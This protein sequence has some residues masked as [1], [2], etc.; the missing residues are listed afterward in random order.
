M[1]EISDP[2][3][4]QQYGQHSL[5]NLAGI[6]RNHQSCVLSALL[7]AMLRLGQSFCFF[8]YLAKAQKLKTFEVCMTQICV[9]AKHPIKNNN[10]VGLY[11]MLK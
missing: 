1:D 11:Y 4:C 8:G 9:C 3:L 7:L 2:F 10:T 5:T 6:D